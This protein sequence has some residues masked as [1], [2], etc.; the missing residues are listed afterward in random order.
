MNLTDA[1]RRE[2]SIF[3]LSQTTG[4]A[5]LI[6]LAW[7]EKTSV[8]DQWS[9]WDF[10]DIPENTVSLCDLLGDQEQL[11][12]AADIALGLLKE[13]VAAAVEQ[14]NAEPTTVQ[15]IEPKP[16]TPLLSDYSRTI[17]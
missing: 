7:R 2:M 10:A 3:T 16:Y 11:K 12:L 5:S 9:E 17:D 13:I 15:A 14:E 6:F 1:I 4:L 8:W